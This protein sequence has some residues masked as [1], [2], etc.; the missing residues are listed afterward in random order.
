MILVMFSQSRGLAVFDE[1]GRLGYIDARSPNEVNYESEEYLAF[2]LAGAKDI[3]AVEVVDLDALRKHLLLRKSREEL[4]NLALILLNSEYSLNTRKE[5]A[6]ELSESDNGEWG[7]VENILLSNPDSDKLDI[8]GALV[9]DTPYKQ[10]FS[11]V[12]KKTKT[13]S[14]L[15][16]A[17][18]ALPN[19][20][21]Q[22]QTRDALLAEA[23]RKGMFRTFVVGKLPSTNNPFARAVAKYTTGLDK[24]ANS[25]QIKNEKWPSTR[26][27]VA[28]DNE[29]R[30]ISEW[31][32]DLIPWRIAA[33]AGEW[34]RVTQRYAS[35][36]ANH[37]LI[38]HIHNISHW[39]KEN[40]MDRWRR[41]CDR[42]WVSKSITL[43]SDLSSDNVSCGQIYSIEIQKRDA[44]RKSKEIEKHDTIKTEESGLHRDLKLMFF[45]EGEGEVVLNCEYL[46]AAGKAS[47][48][49]SS[50]GL[51]FDKIEKSRVSLFETNNNDR[52]PVHGFRPGRVQGYYDNEPPSN[53]STLIGAYALCRIFEDGGGVLSIS[54][55]GESETASALLYTLEKKEKIVFIKGYFAQLLDVLRIR[56][57]SDLNSGLSENYCGWTS[58]RSL[59]KQ[60]GNNHKSVTKEISMIH[61]R[62]VT[63]GFAK[64]VVE[65]RE[66]EVRLN[67][68]LTTVPE[69]ENRKLLD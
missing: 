29:F 51:Y 32:W 34:D 9:F 37:F 67:P 39:E 49:E 31:S 38:P 8:K 30:D 56:L 47:D 1:N 35:R 54:N 66:G 33:L 13:I 52:I 45:C 14:L 6:R 10:T 17:I 40:T 44:R 53:I 43:I 28:K 2:L 41:Y 12:G 68:K 22:N 21:F 36:L 20:V 15:R 23:I 62:I 26:I 16:K 63:A 64:D 5:A 19:H 18:Y 60:A 11:L 4:L 55:K 65:I 46:S 61:N 27:E 25:H 50:R 3:E 58:L 57:F 69:I 59:K 24:I 48:R 42:Y 7:W